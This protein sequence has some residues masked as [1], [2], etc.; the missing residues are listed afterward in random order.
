LSASFFYVLS[1]CAIGVE[2]SAAELGG[3]VVGMR[4][5]GFPSL[6]VPFF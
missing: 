4:M 5:G 3:G 1:F 6:K 2:L